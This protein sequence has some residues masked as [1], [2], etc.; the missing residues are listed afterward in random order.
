MLD[1]WFVGYDELDSFKRQD[2]NTSERGAT[3]PF[4]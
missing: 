3:A 2:D 4:F 1:L